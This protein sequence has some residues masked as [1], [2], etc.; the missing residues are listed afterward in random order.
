MCTNIKTRKNYLFAHACGFCLS[1]VEFVSLVGSLPLVFSV[2]SFISF[3]HGHRNCAG[4]MQQKKSF[5]ST[6][7]FFIITTT[8]IIIRSSLLLELQFRRCTYSALRTTRRHGQG[9]I[10]GQ[11]T[12][13]CTGVVNPRPP[14]QGAE[15]GQ[16]PQRPARV[17][18]P[19]PAPAASP[20]PLRR[21]HAGRR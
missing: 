15:Q 13:R 14:G 8:V 17:V 11:R 19:W 5:I 2:A 20:T 6:L 21:R 7:T 12:Q 10:E 16:P 4:F 1:V 18:N 9:A 3:R